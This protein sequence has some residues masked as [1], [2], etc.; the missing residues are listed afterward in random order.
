M[1]SAGWRPV[2]SGLPAARRPR[3]PRYSAT[4][5]GGPDLFARFRQL[6]PGGERDGKTPGQ[7]RSVNGN[8][9]NWRTR[10]TTKPPR[11]PGVSIPLPP[12]TEGPCSSRSVMGRAGGAVVGLPE[13]SAPASPEGPP[14]RPRGRSAAVAGC[15]ALQEPRA[16]RASKGGSVA[17][18]AC[19][20]RA[21]RRGGATHFR[22]A[23]L[24][25]RPAPSS[26]R[27]G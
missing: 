1:G 25:R 13:R 24:R 10:T 2:A 21:G 4:P 9:S 15:N 20:R 14:E 22:V 27:G 26:A 3:S 7:D 5:A 12:F 16:S 23:V 17:S 19:N 11:N 18:W 6:H 8:L